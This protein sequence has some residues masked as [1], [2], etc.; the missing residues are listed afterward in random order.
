MAPSLCEGVCSKFLA[1]TLAL[2]RHI[3]LV[4]AGQRSEDALFEQCLE[5][6]LEIWHESAMSWLEIFL[7]GGY[8]P[9]ARYATLR[10]DVS[11]KCQRCGLEDETAFHL[12]WGCRCNAD[13]AD[14]RVQDT[15]ALYGQA[16]EHAVHFPC[17]WLRGILPRELVAINTPYATEAV[18][19]YVQS[20]PMDV[21]PDGLYHTD[22]SG[23]EYATMPVLM[24]CGC[25]IA[26]LDQREEEFVCMRQ[27]LFLWG[28]YTPLPGKQQTVP[29]A[30]ESR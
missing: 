21:W 14:H 17:L 15:Q 25:G 4:N 28:V 19:H 1:T 18:L 22:A 12:L 29:R 2:H 8:W 6:Q 7:V 11:A 10:S 3:H 23:G 27:E 20:E 9:Q 5:K 16:C 24:R 26:F 13:I 30:L